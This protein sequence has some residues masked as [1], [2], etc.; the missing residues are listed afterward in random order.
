MTNK[1]IF[2]SIITSVGI[3][4]S[5]Y[6]AGLAITIANSKSITSYGWVTHTQLVTR[7]IQATYTLVVEA[8]SAQ[9]SYLINGNKDFLEPYLNVKENV[10]RHVRVLSQLVKDNPSQSHKIL[11]LQTAIG[12]RIRLLENNIAI[13]NATGYNSERLNIPIQRGRREMLKVKKLTQDMV[14]AED[15]LLIQREEEAQWQFYKLVFAMMFLILRDVIWCGYQIN[16][17]KDS[18]L[19]TYN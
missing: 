4:V 12:N 2:T 15:Q 7:Q 10:D 1:K 17:I 14:H 11:A 5:I 8:E 16:T 6:I 3:L 13:R 9:R 18:N 19:G